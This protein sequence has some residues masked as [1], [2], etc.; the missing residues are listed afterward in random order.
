MSFSH[1]KS[2]SCSFSGKMGT[3]GS[4]KKICERL[5]LGSGTPI[6]Q[7]DGFG[8]GTGPSYVQ[9]EDLRDD[10]CSQKLIFGT[11]F[12]QLNKI[13]MILNDTDMF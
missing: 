10:I 1:L 9:I 2:W 12:L 5:R 11:L 8:G 3:T 7:Q 6:L 13:D 4:P